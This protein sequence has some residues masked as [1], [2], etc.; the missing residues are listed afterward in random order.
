MNWAQTDVTRNAIRYTLALVLTLAA[1]AVRLATDPFLDHRLPYWTFWV[2]TAIAVWR[3]GVGPAIVVASLG[4][5]LGF[6]FFV[7]P[8]HTLLFAGPLD[9]VVLFAYAIICAIICALGGLMRQANT[10]IAAAAILALEQKERVQAEVRERQRSEALLRGVLDSAPAGIWIVDRGGNITGSNAASDRIWGLSR[11][12]GIYNIRNFKAW[13]PSN[14]K[15]IDPPE[16]PSSRAMAEGKPVLDQEIEVETLDGLCRC[17]IDSAVPLRDENGTV[18]GAIAVHVDITRRKEAEAQLK[19][20]RARIELLHEAASKLLSTSGTEEQILQIYEKVGN[21]FGADVFLEYATD[22]TFVKRELVVSGGIPTDAEERLKH[23]QF[24]E[25]FC[26]SIPQ[27]HEPVA[28]YHV[29]QSNDASLQIMKNIG[30]RAYCV[31]PLLVGERLLGSL[32]FAS[33]TKDAFDAADEEIFQ[34]IARYVAI[35]RD[36]WRLTSSLQAYAHDLENAVQER[37]ASLEESSARLRGI[38]ETAVD[39][40]ITFDDHES[41]ETVNPATEK[42]FGYTSAEMLGKNI[43]MILAEPSRTRCGGNLDRYLESGEGDVLGITHELNALRKN[44][45]TFPIQLSLSEA[46]LPNRRFFTCIIRDVTLRK[47]AEERLKERTHELEQ[48]SYSIIHDMRAPL[49]AMRSFGQMLQEDSANVLDTESKDFLRRIIE[50]AARMDQLI[51]DVFNFTAFMREGLPLSPLNPKPLLKGIIE[52][53]PEFDATRADIRILEEFPDVIANRGGLT[54]CCSNLLYNAVKFAKPGQKPVITI[55]SEIR[56]PAV[57]LWFE[58]QGIGIEP[59]H[60]E[61]IFDMFQK[62]DVRSTG[63]GIGLALVKKAVEKMHGTVGVESEPGKG[64][65]FWIE[66]QAAQTEPRA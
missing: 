39:A 53:Y 7:E 42:M 21:F 50:S 47:R 54:Q 15:R 46:R 16:W 65:K 33:R 66:L 58:D 2:A 36:R 52:S 41:I 62:L 59:R 14:K 25:A 51:T 60:Q 64:S 61:R 31:Y 56:G 17:I 8:R 12:H 3:L 43:K 10:R 9:A 37:T 38:V 11:H 23:L 19:Q 13:W 18:T 44:G 26:E 6:Y 48:L 35:A 4:L 34:T 63:T 28:A 40:I 1:L 55:R 49:R 22:N 20:E 30:V 32:A 45:E 5:F 24:T 57:R 29:Q 27:R